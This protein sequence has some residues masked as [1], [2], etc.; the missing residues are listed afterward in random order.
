[1][2]CSQVS[3]CP[4]H[5]TVLLINNNKLQDVSLLWR[6]LRKVR[7]LSIRSNAVSEL[8]EDVMAG[9]ASL[10]SLYLDDNPIQFLPDALSHNVNMCHLTI[11]NTQVPHI[12]HGILHL[13]KLTLLETANNRLD[14]QLQIAALRG[15]EELRKAYD[16][17]IPDAPPQISAVQLRRNA[18]KA[19]QNG[20]S[21]VEKR[22]SKV[23]DGQGRE[24]KRSSKAP[25]EPA[26][27]EEKRSSRGVQD[28]TLPRDDKRSPRGATQDS[29]LT[30]EDRN[31]TKVTKED[32]RDENR[33]AQQSTLPRDDM[34]Q[35][36]PADNRYATEPKRLPRTNLDSR[37][38]GERETNNNTVLLDKP[39]PNTKPKPALQAKPKAADK[40][41]VSA[42][43][44]VNGGQKSSFLFSRPK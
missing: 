10:H 35:S 36:R 21:G 39:K 26:S 41:E 25:K 44:Q 30:R 16:K 18:S 4:S 9:A 11:S 34:R 2:L 5:V 33:S 27:N 20:P 3:G 40:P 31:S 6:A 23:M 29:T 17:F 15:V 13:P 37:E 8:P 7:T 12:P 14:P 28:G 24:E 32:A 38:N 19:E 42:K 43:P 1:M 22:S